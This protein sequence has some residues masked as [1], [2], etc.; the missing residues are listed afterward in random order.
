MIVEGHAEARKVVGDWFET[1][2]LKWENG[3]EAG[4]GAFFAVKIAAAGLHSVA[5]VLVDE[6]KAE[7]TRQKHVITH[8]QYVQGKK[9]IA[10]TAYQIGHGM[11]TLGSRVLRLNKH[12]RY[13]WQQRGDVVPRLRMESGR[14]MPRQEEVAN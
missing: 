1:E 12:I 10:R 14:V 5:L 4:S 11:S 8:D 2:A 9:G 13:D 7:I 6:E 3:S